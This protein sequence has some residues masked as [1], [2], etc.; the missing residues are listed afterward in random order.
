[1]RHLVGRVVED[2]QVSGQQDEDHRDDGG[3]R[4]Q[5]NV[6]DHLR[7]PD[8]SPTRACGPASPGLLRGPVDDD[9]RGGVLPSD[10]AQ[11]IATEWAVSRER[12]ATGMQDRDRLYIDGAW[13]PSTGKGPID[14]ISP[15]PG[16]G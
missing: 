15:A 12:K 6:H 3:P 10:A 2:E 11:A 9:R 13:A 5:G 7:Q 4:P 16:E 8:V 1:Q 14:V